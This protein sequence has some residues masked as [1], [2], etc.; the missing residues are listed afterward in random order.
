MITHCCPPYSGS[1]DVP[2]E[3]PAKEYPFQLDP[4]QQAAIGFIEKGGYL[5]LNRSCGSVCGVYMYIS[6]STEALCFLYVI[7]S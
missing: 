6:G 5:C 1:Q 4:F 3:K 2:L 7:H